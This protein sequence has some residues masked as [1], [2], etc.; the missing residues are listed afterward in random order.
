M[1]AQDVRLSHLPL[2]PWGFGRSKRQASG[3]NCHRA[4]RNQGLFWMCERG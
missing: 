1:M 2:G 4:G 3:P